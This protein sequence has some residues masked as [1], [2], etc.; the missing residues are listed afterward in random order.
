MKN[1]VLVIAILFGLQG[2]SQDYKEDMKKMADKFAQSSE[3]SIDMDVY[4]YYDRAGNKKENLG[5]ALIRKDGNKYYTRF[6]Q[7]EYISDGKR[8]LIIDH[9]AKSMALYPGALDLKGAQK[10]FAD[11]DFTKIVKESDSVKYLGEVSSRKK[12]EVRNNDPYVERS[13]ITFSTDQIQNITYY[14]RASNEQFSVEMDHVSIEYENISTSVEGEFFNLGRYLIKKGSKASL[15]EE[16][17]DYSLEIM[18]KEKNNFD[19]N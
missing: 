9:Q 6:E 3:L 18:T 17:L 16:Y 19:I 4:L 7:T 2:W 14:Y 11:V 1:T 8:T 5:K 10:N 13:V 15:S 12:Y